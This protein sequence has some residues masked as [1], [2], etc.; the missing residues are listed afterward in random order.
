MDGSAAVG[1]SFAELMSVRKGNTKLL[2]QRSVVSSC[3]CREAIREHQLFWVLLFRQ[4]PIYKE[5]GFN[6][7]I[8]IKPHESSILEKV[9]KDSLLSIFYASA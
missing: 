4:G 1:L 8:S 3:G 2:A 5:I 7:G 6:I 9:R